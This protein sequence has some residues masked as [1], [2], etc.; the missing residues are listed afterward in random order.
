MT[1]LIIAITVA[2]V[3]SYVAINNLKHVK[4]Q[5]ILSMVG[6]AWET[7]TWIWETTFKP[8]AKMT[9][10]FILFFAVVI[11]VSIATI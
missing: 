10:G 4:K 8:I 6:K 5:A 11:A 1:K 3:L 9:I 7:A 2:N